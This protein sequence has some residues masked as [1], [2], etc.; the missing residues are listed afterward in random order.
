M[1]LILKGKS[2]GHIIITESFH[3]MIPE[4]IKLFHVFFQNPF[5]IN[6]CCVGASSDCNNGMIGDKEVNFQI[7]ENKTVPENV[8]L[9]IL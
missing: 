6:T 3:W 9:K 7:Q 5:R 4:L 2:R 8:N 1:E